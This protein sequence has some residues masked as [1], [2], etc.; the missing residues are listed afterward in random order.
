[1]LANAPIT[2]FVYIGVVTGLLCLAYFEDQRWH[3]WEVAMGP[4]PWLPPGLCF[5]TW[6]PR[7]RI[8][9]AMEPPPRRRAAKEKVKNLGNAEWATPP[10][11]RLSMNTSTG[12][13]RHG[14][15]PS[16][17]QMHASPG[18]NH[19]MGS[20]RSRIT[21][22]QINTAPPQDALPQKKKTQKQRKEFPGAV[23]PAKKKSKKMAAA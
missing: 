2:A 16:A 6:V 23:V 12:F 18:H 5:P 17:A 1:M 20:A 15:G 9:D 8:V 21:V 4:R 13:F 3:G 11:R 19:A 22:P 14:T 10:P 7:I